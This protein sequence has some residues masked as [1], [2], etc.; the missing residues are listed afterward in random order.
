MTDNP[1]DEVAAAERAAL[2]ARMVLA[3]SDY[4]AEGKDPA[5]M[6]STIA[7]MFPE[8]PTTTIYRWMN[9]GIKQGA[10]GRALA[11][12]KRAEAEV[13]VMGVSAV[14]AAAT[15][16]PR[17]TIGNI[18]IFE[19]LHTSITAMEGVLAYA[20]GPDAAKPRNPKLTLT[21]AGMIART[22]ETALSIHEALT[23]ARRLDDFHA[24]MIAEIEAESPELAARVI[25]RLQALTGQIGA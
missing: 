7:A 20:Q 16:I 24:A 23:Q 11:D 17:G 18:P 14:G 5:A 9:A 3:L 12:R 1:K 19:K 25:G 13:E 10:P 22:L 2:R 6:R 4:I 8:V 21:A 15:V